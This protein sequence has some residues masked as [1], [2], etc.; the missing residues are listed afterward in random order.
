MNLDRAEALMETNPWNVDRRQ[1]ATNYIV[2]WSSRVADGAWQHHIAEATL[3]FILRG[4][5]A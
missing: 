2:L 3:L 5:K 4:L 1:L